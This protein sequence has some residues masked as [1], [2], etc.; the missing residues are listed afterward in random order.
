MNM[1]TIKLFAKNKNLICLGGPTNNIT[2]EFYENA[3]PRLLYLRYQKQDETVVEQTPEKVFQKYRDCNDLNTVW[4][5]KFF[6]NK[7]RTFY[8]GSNLAVFGRYQNPFASTES[9]V[10]IIAGLDGKLTCACA[11]YVTT[12][13]KT[14]CFGFKKTISTKL[15]R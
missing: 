2:F 12:K 4:V 3:M 9:Q 5:E 8:R 14:N 1:M 13:S 11:E 6:D 7:K 10:I 15:D